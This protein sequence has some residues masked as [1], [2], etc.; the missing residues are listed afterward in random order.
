MGLEAYYTRKSP[1]HL[2]Q[3]RTGVT[4]HWHAADH[5]ERVL[6]RCCKPRLNADVLILPPST[7]MKHRP[8]VP[9]A[10]PT[11]VYQQFAVDEHLFDTDCALHDSR[12][13]PRYISE[14]FALSGPDGVGIE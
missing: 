7:T 8:G 9:V 11:T 14:G 2:R 3:N 4:A 12:A 5:G 10:L 13:T 6:F 1:K